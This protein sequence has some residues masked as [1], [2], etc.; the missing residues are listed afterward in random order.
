M[1]LFY[2]QTGVLC[3]VGAQPTS[4]ADVYG[5]RNDT[6]HRQIQEDACRL[7]GEM[8]TVIGTCASGRMSGVE[9]GVFRARPQA[10]K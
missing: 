1:K 9:I 3:A 4:S 7:G 8:V 2:V 10:A 5:E 6:L